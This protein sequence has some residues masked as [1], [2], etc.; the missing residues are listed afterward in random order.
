MEQWLPVALA[1]STTISLILLSI[2]PGRGQESDRYQVL[3]LGDIGRSPRMQ[4]HAL[5][6]ANHGRP[7]DLIGYTGEKSVQSQEYLKGVLTT[8]RLVIASSNPV[9]CID[10]RTLSSTHP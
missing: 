6:L 8:E 4:Y 5:S 1:I 7:V 10:T 9:E 2:P 3:V